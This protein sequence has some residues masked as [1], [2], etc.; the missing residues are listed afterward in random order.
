MIFDRRI[1]VKIFAD[2]RIELDT[3]DVVFYDSVEKIDYV[4]DGALICITMKNMIVVYPVSRIMKM[5]IT[6]NTEG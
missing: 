1:N 5:T 4:N 6:E 2:L 3:D